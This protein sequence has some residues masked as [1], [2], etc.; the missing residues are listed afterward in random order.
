MRV[1]HLISQKK[2]QRSDSGWQTTDMPPRHSPIYTKSR[3]IRAGWKWRAA[4]CESE[5]GVK[6]ILTALCNTA[7][8]NWKA[9]LM[10]ETD[11]GTSVVAR[12]EHHGSHPGLHAHSHC[13]RGGTEV[14][15]GGLDDLV[16]APKE[17]KTH[18]RNNAWTETTFW[19]AARKFFRI[20]DDNGPLFDHGT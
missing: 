3:P 16:R 11:A 2:T 12:F 14:G 19:Q 7:R 15:A 18:R 4:H 6:Y 10:L 13:E 17:G 1:R 8:D 9:V 20:E 5:N